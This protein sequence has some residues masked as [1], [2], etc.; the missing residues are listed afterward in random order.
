MKA[1]VQ[2]LLNIIKEDILL[3]RVLRNTSYLF[4]S[5]AISM[6]L[7]MGQSILATRL[8][9]ANLYGLLVVVMTFATNINRLFS[10][11]IGEFVIQF[12]GKELVKK[13]NLRAGA[14]AKAALLTESATSIITFIVF[15]LLIPIGAQI[16]A[17]NPTTTGLFQLYG[18][19]ILANLC[20][21]S[22]VGILQITNHFKI[23]AVI[24][25]TQSIV[26]AGLILVAFL[27]KGSILFVL[28]AY[29][30]GK[31]ITG[32]GPV[33]AALVAL[34]KKLGKGWWK[35]PF[36]V[37]PSIKEMAGFT[38][39]TNLSGTIKMLVSGSEPLLIGLFLDTSAVALYK[40][41]ISIAEPLMIPI[42]Q[43]I[44]TTFPEMTKTIAQRS[45]RQLRQLLRRVTIISGTWTILFILAM[46]F[47][48]PWILSIWGKEYVPAYSTMMILL[49]G[50]GFSNIFYWNRSLLL[51]FGKANIPLYILFGTAVLKTA[52]AFVIVPVYGMASEAWLLSGNFVV[53]VGL[54]VIIGYSL[55]RKNEQLDAQKAEAAT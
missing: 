33:V 19:F 49:V 7:A 24:N 42:S 45:W 51:S 47:F 17:K 15:M 1:W 31:F 25:V 32:L 41:A 5:Q 22:A 14:V 10:F 54:M 26:T 9:G 44:N 38:I 18:L 16:F 28:W 8:L 23:Q 30:I 43:F 4:S 36:S 21:E 50:Y 48:G 40:I 39:S 27:M 2:K 53:S 20:N 55:I 52:L 34:S 29:L 46:L 37:F 12:M 3:R 6:V 35:A 11:R 13:D